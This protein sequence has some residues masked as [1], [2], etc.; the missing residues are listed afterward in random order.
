MRPSALARDQLTVFMYILA[1]HRVQ[2][3]V[4][5]GYE[6]VEYAGW[7]DPAGLKKDSPLLPLLSKKM[8]LTKIVETIYQP[9]TITDDFIFEFAPTDG[10][11]HRV[12]YHIN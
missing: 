10:I 6:S 3:P 12:V 8:F 11:Y 5:F 1:D 2:K 4:S 9:A 7:V